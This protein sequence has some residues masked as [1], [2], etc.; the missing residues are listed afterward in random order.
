MHL[1][2]APV[3][4]MV[5]TV[6]PLRAA[7]TRFTVAQP[8][9]YAFD[10]GLYRGQL[11]LDGKYQGLYPLVDVASGADLVRPPGIFSPYRLFS[12]KQRFGNAA[13]D[14]PTSSR[15]LDDGAVASHWASV[16]H[17]VELD[18]VY[19][20]STADTLDFEV[21]VQPKRDLPDFELF[22][23]SYFLKGFRAAA[24]V[25]DRGSDKADF[26]PVDRPSDQPGGYVM[27]PRDEAAIARIQG[28]R[29]DV[30][31][32]PVRWAIGRFL[33]APLILRRDAQLGLTGAMMC[34]A[35]DCFAVSSPW[36]PDTPEA[37]GY[38]SIYLSLF[39]RDLKA[40]QPAKARCRMVLARELTD[41]EVLRR[42]REWK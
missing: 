20:W 2:F 19:R 13:R 26:A 1:R 18:T 39:G 27:F 16:E 22:M 11:K 24:Y 38:R 12:G 42:Y 31:P 29:W 28:G 17:P 10:T 4:L 15:L 21:T 33:A 36:N 6:V 37:G 8:G 14:W 23:S 40:G 41:A 32:S 3:A 9:L 25:R 34:P 35:E 7:E 30:P 5:L